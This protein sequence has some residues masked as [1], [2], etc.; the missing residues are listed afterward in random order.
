MMIEAEGRVAVRIQLSA[1]IEAVAVTYGAINIMSLFGYRTDTADGEAAAEVYAASV[2]KASSLFRW[3][4]D[5]DRITED[6]ELLPML[7][8]LALMSKELERLT[9][10]AAEVEDTNIRFDNIVA[11]LRKEGKEDYDRQ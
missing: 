9:G 2:R 6:P 4:R 3:L 10:L 11:N 7:E 1:L 5:E 8:A